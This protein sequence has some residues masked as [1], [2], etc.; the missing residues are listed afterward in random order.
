MLAGPQRVGRAD[1]RR[2]RTT[3]ECRRCR[4]PPRRPSTG[5][6][7]EVQVAAPRWRIGW[8]PRRGQIVRT[9][10]AAASSGSWW[11]AAPPYSRPGTALLRC[12]NQK[13]PFVRTIMRETNRSRPGGGHGFALAEPTLDLATLHQAVDIALSLSRLDAV[14]GREL[15]H[16]IVIALE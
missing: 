10:S 2:S 5:P 9:R 11:A 12:C 16:Q 6:P 14:L 13:R 3:G 8:R 15:R 4:M 7:E 1:I